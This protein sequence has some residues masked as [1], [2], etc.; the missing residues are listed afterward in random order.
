MTQSKAQANAE[1]TYFP[2]EGLAPEAVFAE[3]DAA[4]ANDV[5]W[6]DGRLGLYVHFGGDDVLAVAKEAYLRFFSENA[7]GPSAFPS[8]KKFE[9]EV[10]AWTGDLLGGHDVAGNITSGGTESIFLAMKSMRDRARARGE[11][12]DWPEVVA[13]FSAHAGFDKA[14]HLMNMRVIRTPLRDDLRADVDAMREAVTPDTIGMVGSAPG[15]P[16]GVVDPIEDIAAVARAHDLWLHV[17]CCVGG[18]ILPHARAL[19]YRVPAFDFSVPGVCSISADLHKYGFA[20][21]GASTVVYRDAELH[22]FQP[23]VFEDWPRGRYAVPTFAGSRPGGAVAAAWAVMRYLG[24]AGYERIVG[25]IMGACTRLAE[26]I[27]A[28]PELRVLGDPEGPIMTYG[29][30]ELDIFAVAEALEEQGW[31]VTRG[32]EPPCIHLGMLTMMHVPVIDRYLTDL[33]GAVQAVRDGRVRKG[34]ARVTY[35]G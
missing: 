11:G 17:D 28:E 34:A 12:G 29:A 35:G 18:Y 23:Y 2:K 19:G 1:S 3:L 27:H 6:R 20:A 10:V 14:A 7:L 5:D 8:L 26:G 15:F 25:D 30:D 24:R 32:A 13:P 33:R 21:K 9:T 22:S 16:H 31:F 4:S